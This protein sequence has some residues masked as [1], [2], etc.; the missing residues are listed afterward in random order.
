MGLSR[1][2]VMKPDS[3]IPSFIH[4]PRSEPPKYVLHRQPPPPRTR[5][6][7]GDPTDLEGPSGR[8]IVRRHASLLFPVNPKQASSPFPLVRFG[9]VGTGECKL[10][11]L[12]TFVNEFNGCDTITLLA[13]KL[14][15]CEAFRACV[16]QAEHRLGDQL[17]GSRANHGREYIEDRFATFFLS[18]PKLPAADWLTGHSD[19]CQLSVLNLLTVNSHSSLQ[20]LHFHYPLQLT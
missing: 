7:R 11:L 1:R 19:E 3:Y 5:A 2:E 6:E 20:L 18:R 14:S 12:L 8:Q 13:R 4:S 16:R 10:L 15:A 17:M 9:L